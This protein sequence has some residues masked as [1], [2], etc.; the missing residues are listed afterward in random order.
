[1]VEN[2]LK[3]YGFQTYFCGH[4]H[5]LGYSKHDGIAYYL[6]GSFGNDQD[7][8]PP[9]KDKVFGFLKSR[10][11]EGKLYGTYYYSTDLVKWKNWQAPVFEF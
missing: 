1:M 11:I 5:K 10:L 7:W 2:L 8:Q 9:K 4:S 3:N 6:S